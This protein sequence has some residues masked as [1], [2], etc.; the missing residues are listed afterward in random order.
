[1]AANQQNIWQQYFGIHACSEI[2]HS[3]SSTK[4]DSLPMHSTVYTLCNRK[5]ISKHKRLFEH[6]L[7]SIIW[8]D[9]SCCFWCLREKY[10]LF[11]NRALSALLIMFSKITWGF[12]IPSAICS[13]RLPMWTMG[14]RD[15]WLDNEF[16]LWPLWTMPAWESNKMN[17]L[18]LFY[19]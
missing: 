4:L 13:Q 11:T 16:D 2:S 7:D 8:V 18:Q 19:V 1:M 17:W 12:P 5:K 15:T 3:P 6:K 10:V 14:V 9:R